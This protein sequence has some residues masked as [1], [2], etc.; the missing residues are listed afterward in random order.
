[1]GLFRNPTGWGKCKIRNH[2]KQRIGGFKQSPNHSQNMCTAKKLPNTEQAGRN[3]VYFSDEKQA[4]VLEK[5]RKDGRT[6]LKMQINQPRL[7]EKKEAAENP[8][9]M[10]LSQRWK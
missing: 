5:T 9:Q 4:G 6:A 3:N 10:L 1:M 8:E 7:Y 2:F